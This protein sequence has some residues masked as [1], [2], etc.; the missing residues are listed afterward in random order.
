M[1]SPFCMSP[2]PNFLGLRSL[3][4]HLAVWVPSPNFLV[5]YAF[6]VVSKKSRLLVLP[7]TSCFCTSSRPHLRSIQPP[8]EWS[9]VRSWPHTPKLRMRGAVPQ[10]LHKF[11]SQWFSNDISNPNYEG[12]S[13][14][15]SRSQMDIKRKTFDIRLCIKKHLFLDISSTNI[16]TFVQSLYHCVETRNR[17]LSAVFSATSAP[18]SQPLRHQRNGCH[19]GAF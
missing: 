18:P 19:Q 7:G 12:E 16:V 1:R 8:V 11:T 15:T 6:R 14:N 10:L 5:F 13:I 2:S 4:N 3:W 17:S 9:R